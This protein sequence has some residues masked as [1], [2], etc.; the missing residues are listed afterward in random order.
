LKLRQTLLAL[1]RYIALIACAFLVVFGVTGSI[2]AFEPEL[3]NLLHPTLSYVTP[4]PAARSLAEISDAVVRARPDGR[5]VGYTIPSAP[6][7]SY[8]VREADATVFVDPYSGRL[9]GTRTLAPDW[10]A[11]VHQLHLRLLIRNRSDSGK[12]IMS[13]AGVTLIVLLL[14]GVWLW[15]PLKRFTV[16]RTGTR[17][18]Q[19]F[20]LHAASGILSF[21][22]LLVLAGTGVVIGF[23]RMTSP[24]LYRISRSEPSAPAATEIVAPAGAIPVSADSV[25]VIAAAA[26]PGAAV[27]RIDLPRPGQPYIVRMRYPEDRTPGGRSEVR[28]EPYS[29]AVLFAEGSRTA[30]AGARMIIANRAFH[31]GDRFG[32]ASKTLVS[33]AS[34]ALVLQ[35]VSGFV[36][37]GRRRRR[38]V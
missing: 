36:V 9:L 4:G 22:F 7:L 18:R 32:L 17:T 1:H 5:V 14:S 25:R 2:M 10:L 13:W 19:W 31:T 21:V 26:L 35:V 34:L 6:R 15:W 16:R 29:A 11:K 23:E 20:D 30:P 3:E 37:W 28:I 8:Q 27:F 33:L 38:A 24:L 12:K